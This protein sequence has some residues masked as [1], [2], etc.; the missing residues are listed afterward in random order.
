MKK[1]FGRKVLQVMRYNL[2]FVIMA[3]MFSVMALAGN[4]V[5]REG[6]LSADNMCYS[7]GTN[8]VGAN[9]TSLAFTNRSNSFMGTQ[10][11]NGSVKVNLNTGGYWNESHGAIRINNS[12]IYGQSVLWFLFNGG[13]M[14]KIRADYAGYM[15][16]G[17]LTGYNWWAGA[18]DYFDG[19]YYYNPI[20]YL[21]DLGLETKNGAVFANEGWY[22]IS[23]TSSYDVCTVK[24]TEYTCSDSSCTSTY[25]REICTDWCTLQIHGGIVTECI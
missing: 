10:T 19:T 20:M 1:G 9:Y 18:I 17:A 8:C 23:D 21:D 12:N 22:G 3:I 6:N 24:N 16:F 2:V 13:A 25:Q 15:N 14:S 11:I 5:V 4:V 7:N